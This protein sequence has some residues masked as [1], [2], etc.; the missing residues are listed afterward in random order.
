VAGV[1][2]LTA[3]TIPAV[4]LHRNPTP[5]FTQSGR[6]LGP[7]RL[8]ARGRFQAPPRG[9]RVDHGQPVGEPRDQL[10]I[11]L[12][13]NPRWSDTAIRAPEP[14]NRRTTENGEAAWRT[15]FVASSVRSEGRQRPLCRVRL[16]Q[17]GHDVTPRLH[18]RTKIRRI[19]GRKLHWLR[20]DGRV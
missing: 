12:R 14:R 17:H 1:V 16:V 3:T 18:G 9:D 5:L 19:V 8:S 15:A 2:V 7:H 11:W 6:K 20:N 10:G 13:C 4:R